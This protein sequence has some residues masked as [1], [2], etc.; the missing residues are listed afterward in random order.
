MQANYQQSKLDKMSEP[1]LL[2]SYN[3]NGWWNVTVLLII[4]FI[5]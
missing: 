2:D 5:Y 1:K 4:L 3:I